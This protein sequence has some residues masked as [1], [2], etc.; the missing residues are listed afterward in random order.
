MSSHPE[1]QWRDYLTSIFYIGIPLAFYPLHNHVLKTFAS[2]DSLRLVRSHDGGPHSSTEDG[3][4]MIQ[5][6]DISC[7]MQVNTHS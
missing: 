1:I 7:L 5:H 6:E 3:F 4:R 2:Q